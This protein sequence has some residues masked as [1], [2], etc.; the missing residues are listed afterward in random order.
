MSDI[1]SDPPLTRESVQAAHELIKPF[2]HRTPVLT[3]TTL[4]ELASTPRNAEDLVGTPW[5]GRVPAKPKVRLWFKCEN[6]QK[7]GAFKVRGAF[8]KCTFC[9]DTII[10]NTQWIYCEHCY[11]N[12]NRQTQLN[13]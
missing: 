12:L 8:R 7:I 13:S 4:T 10:P 1:T 11:T 3:N 6:F 2:V 9:S 5:E